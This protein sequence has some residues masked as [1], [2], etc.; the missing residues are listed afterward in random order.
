M[1]EP[2]VIDDRLLDA[3]A[4]KESGNDP[5]AIGDEGL[6]YPAY[7]AFQMRRPAYLDVTRAHPELADQ[8]L[9]ESLQ[10]ATR[11]R[12]LAQAYLELLR[13]HY[14]L[15]TLDELLQGYNAGPTAVRRGNVPESSRAYATEIQAL[16]GAP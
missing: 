12:T 7:G 6:R 3:L 15:D 4:Q 10:D 5:T 13:D 11:Q 14:G 1:P 8:T 2:L 16:M 9:E